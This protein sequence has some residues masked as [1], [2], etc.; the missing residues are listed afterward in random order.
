VTW[1][2]PIYYTAKNE[3]TKEITTTIL[4][5]SNKSFNPQ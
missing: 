1:E 4:F 2:Q 5:L 3:T